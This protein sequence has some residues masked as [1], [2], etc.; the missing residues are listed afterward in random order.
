MGRFVSLATVVIVLFT[1]IA[2]ITQNIDL[3]KIKPLTIEAAEELR[4]AAIRDELSL[5]EYQDIMNISCSVLR[6]LPHNKDF[7]ILLREYERR[8]YDDRL[9]NEISEIFLNFRSFLEFLRIERNLLLEAGLPEETVDEFLG[10]IM[11]VR[12][13]AA[14]FKLDVEALQ[15]DL[16]R[17]AE[18]A[19]SASE[20]VS[21]S[22]E[23]NEM[24]C[25][26]GRFGTFAIGAGAAIVDGAA[27]FVTKIPPAAVTA[28][29]LAGSALMSGAAVIPQC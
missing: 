29:G 12:L 17:L 7:A 21:E 5:K 10:Q 11:R 26:I 4:R 27:L 9:A 24:R 19:C 16:R 14:G 13:E 23:R 25:N 22:I 2:A 3:A 18:Q 1:P 8:Q 20:N 6:E 15:S 28:S